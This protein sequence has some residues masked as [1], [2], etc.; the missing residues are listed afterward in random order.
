MLLGQLLIGAPAAWAFARL[1]FPGRRGIFALYVLLMVLPFQVTQVSNYLVLD[2]LGLLN[3]HLALILPGIWSTFPVFIMTRSFEAVPGALLE[4]AYL[5]GA[6]ELQAFFL[7]GLPAG[8]P[9]IVTAMV[10]SFIDAWNALEQPVAYLKDMSLWPLSLSLPEIVSD[11]AAVAFAAGIVMM[12]PPV[13]VSERGGRT[14]AGFG[15][16]RC[17]GVGGHGEDTEKKK[18]VLPDAADGIFP[19]DVFLHDSFPDL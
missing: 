5:D 1:K 17:E 13:L 8:Y 2:C 15:S 3:S 16:L 4:A 14:G 19:A 18:P 7:V 9:G 11:K 6:G 12:L 10:L